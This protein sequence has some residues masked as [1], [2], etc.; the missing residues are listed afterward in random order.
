MRTYSRVLG[1]ALA[2]GAAVTLLWFGT[3]W[4]PQ[5][6]SPAPATVFA[7]MALLP[8]TAASTVTFTVLLPG[9][10]SGDGVVGPADLQLLADS[11][12]LTAGDPGWNPAFD[13]TQDGLID[14]LDFY[15]VARR[16]GSQ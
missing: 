11:Y 13:L 15:A 2:A 7:Q 1:A 10:L 16:V 4:L 3:A 6:A 8:A 9:D 12:L 14:L 5:T